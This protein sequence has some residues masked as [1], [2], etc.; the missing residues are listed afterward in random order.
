MKVEFIHEDVNYSFK[1]TTGEE[2]LGPLDTGKVVHMGET[3][4]GG[5][6]VEQWT[7]NLINRI[8]RTVYVNRLYEL[9]TPNVLKLTWELGSIFRKVRSKMPEAT[10]NMTWYK[11]DGQ[12]VEQDVFHGGYAQSRYWNDKDAFQFDNSIPEEI[13]KQSFTS[14]DE[15][16]SFWNM[17]ATELENAFRIDLHDLTMMLYSNFIGETLYDEFNTTSDFSNK[18]GLR[19]VNLLK[20]YNDKHDTSLTFEEAWESPDY[21]RFASY[22]IGKYP[23]RLKH[24]DN[25]FNISKTV[26]STPNDR[27]KVVMLS[28]FMKAANV[29]L[30]SD[31]WHNDM[32]KFPE[33]AEVACWQSPDDDFSEESASTIH[34]VTNNNHEITVKGVVCVM[35]DID[36]LGILC[37]NRR[38][39]THYNA[40]GEFYNYFHKYE[41]NYFNDPDE[42]FV[43][44]F[45]E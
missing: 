32:T 37:E 9:D 45:M 39:K 20:L 36:A 21:L 4:L 31:T 10:K 14:Y 40:N 13:I 22:V 6:L 5:N 34:I 24:P 23:A 44:F 33:A 29:Y 3:I 7:D 19:G 42:Q 35:H 30:Q 41:A 15:M 27:L 17:I 26:K 18:T 25:M 38:T 16:M 11:K 43:V 28:D 12:V 8:G 1:Q 2:S